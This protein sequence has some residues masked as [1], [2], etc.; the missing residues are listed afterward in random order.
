MNNENNAHLLGN[1]IL[2]ASQGS[3]HKI[4]QVQMPSMKKVSSREK[5]NKAV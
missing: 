3:D 5:V 2:T 4:R 1:D